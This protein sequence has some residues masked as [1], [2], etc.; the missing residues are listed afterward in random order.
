MTRFSWIRLCR[1]TQA[2][3]SFGAGIPIITCPKTKPHPT[4]RQPN[5]P[6]GKLRKILTHANTLDWDYN[7]NVIYL[8]LRNTNTFYKI[9]QTTGNL[10]WACGE[11]GNFTLLGANGQPLLGVNGLPPSLWYHCHDVKEVSPD[12]FLIFDNDYENNTNPDDCHSQ[13]IEVTLNETSMTAYVN[14]SWEAPI[15]YW[16]NYGGGA[17]LLPNGDF[18]GNFGDPTHQL[19]QNSVGGGNQSWVFSD[20][21]AV[22]VEVNP[23]GQVV[24][25]GRFRWAGTFTE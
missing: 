17:L 15:Q 3:M 19:V 2:A 20:S 8:N 1:L 7:N 10:I 12:V 16:D 5:C 24:K 25:L 13:I 4:M 6:A 14:W 9:N 18:L 21:G 11:F 23:S 22:F